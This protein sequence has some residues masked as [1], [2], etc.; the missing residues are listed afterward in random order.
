MM[1]NKVPRIAI[2]VMGG[3]HGPQVLIP[4]AVEAAK[5][6]S[7]SLAL[8]GRE[9]IIYSLLEKQKASDLD[10]SVLHAEEK[11]EMS[12][13][14]SHLMRRKKNTSIQVALDAIKD[15]QVEGL[16]SAGPTGVTVA[17]GILTLGRIKGIDRP[18][19]AA[20]L[21]RKNKPLILV[22][23]GANVDTKPRNLVQFALMADVLA[24][25]VLK[26]TDPQIGLLNIGEEQGKGNV[27][28]S[29]TYTL[30]KKM[31]MNFV[32]NVEGRDIFQGDQDI[33]IC[34]GFVGNVVL[35]LSEGLGGVFAKMLQTELK[36]GLLSR[37]GAFFSFSA[38]RRFRRKLDYEEYGGAPLLGLNGTV[39]V[40]HGAARQKAI[41]KAIDM[42]ATS[43]AT[44]ANEDI[45]LGLEAHPEISRFQRLKKILHPSALR[46]TSQEEHE[47][48]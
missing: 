12:D 31:P 1:K 29:E 32:G 17:C 24:K 30:L 45:R 3:D 10:I 35:K 18:A 9:E 48:N 41:V 19:L 37:L 20:F 47:E 27:Q 28:V 40:C 16:V 36:K 15:G 22:D 11:A 25:D 33:V 38:F 2:D 21:P 39:F 8:V 14:P 42:A 44:K 26:V 6:R 23:V 5:K 43:I 7:L 34:D 4:G 46:H 13:K